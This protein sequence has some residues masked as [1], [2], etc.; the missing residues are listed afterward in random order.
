L[1]IGPRLRYHAVPLG[2]E[3]GPFLT[4]LSSDPVQLSEL[5]PPVR[6]VI[7]KVDLPSFLQLFVTQQCPLCPLTVQQLLPLPAASEHIRLAIIDGTLFPEVAEQYSIRSAPTLLLD[8]QFRWTGSVPLQE[9]VQM[10]SDRDPANLGAGS[11]E[12]MLKEGNAF[13][14][15]QMMLERDEVFSALFG[16]LVHEKMFVRLGAM[17]VMEMIADQNAALAAQVIAPLWE[18]FP[19]VP[20]QVKG[21]I[22][23]VLGE[24][25]DKSVISKL[26]VVLSGQFADEV[27][28]AAREAL[29]EIKA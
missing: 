29:E 4:A 14:V 7:E 19:H 21:D 27:K 1:G 5:G 11:L 16:L 15:A 3:L 22:I 10:I 20:D 23:H 17:V 8:E 28:E 24:V 2:K 26:E 9:L 25:G 13:R 12:S 6:G 18:R